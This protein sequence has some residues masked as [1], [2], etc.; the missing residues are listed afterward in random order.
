MHRIVVEWY[1]SRRFVERYKMRDR[2]VVELSFF[3]IF[4]VLYCRL[5]AWWHRVEP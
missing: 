4:R 1:W 5:D 3:V 2:R